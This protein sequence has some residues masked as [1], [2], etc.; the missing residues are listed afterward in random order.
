MKY[1]EALLISEGNKLNRLEKYHSKNGYIIVSAQRGENSEE[2]NNKNKN[3]LK[4]EL[5]RTGFSFREVKGYYKEFNMKEPSLEKSFIVYAGDKEKSKE[6]Y[7]FAIRCCKIF[8]QDSV[9]IAKPNEN[10][11]YFSKDGKQLDWS[12]FTNTIYGEDAKK[13]MAYTSFN[14]ISHNLDKYKKSNKQLKKENTFSF[15]Q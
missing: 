13:Q 12:T 15:V 1:E 6:L 14:K 9:L 10:P 11:Q 8:G 4:K 7:N 2:E 3:I 5:G